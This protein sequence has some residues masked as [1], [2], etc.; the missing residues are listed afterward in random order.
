MLDLKTLFGDIYY[1]QVNC[2]FSQF[3]ILHII[4]LHLST[5]N[6]RLSVAGGEDVFRVPSQNR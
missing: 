2:F 1:Q 6:R 4:V 3:F 5:L